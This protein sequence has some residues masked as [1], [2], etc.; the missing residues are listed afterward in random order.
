MPNPAVS[1]DV[2]AASARAFLVHAGAVARFLRGVGVPR[3]DLDDVVQQVFLT[4]HEKGGYQPG[5]AAERTWYLR[6]AWYAHV[7]YRRRHRNAPVAEAGANADVEPWAE[8]AQTRTIAARE[9]LSQVERALAE[10]PDEHRAVLFMFDVEGN[11][12]K[13]IAQALEV[14]I[15]TVHSRLHN[16]R[17]KLAAALGGEDAP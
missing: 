6:L 5:A 16:G 17:K 13:E 2:A 10:L 14:P 7:A 15:G 12:A 9:R 4:A 1:T 3:V 11:S 8:A